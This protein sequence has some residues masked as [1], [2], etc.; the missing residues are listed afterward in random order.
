M[1]DT[2]FGL[3]THA[4]IVHAVVI[5]LPLAAAG[6]VAVALVPP[7]RRRYGLVVA[8]LAVVAVGSV[9]IATHSGAH[10][11]DRK[12]AVFGPNDT[13]EAGLMEEHRH[14]ALQLWPWALTL[15]LATLVVVGV[16]LLF[17][18][19]T[20]IGSH[21]N[22]GLGA[23]PTTTMPL[24]AKLVSWLGIAG[25]LVGAVA[26]TIMVVRIGHAG[27]KAVWDKLINNSATAPR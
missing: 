12:S 8:A 13:A 20:S 2:I 7:L 17:A 26:S 14:L 6:A 4:L 21:R 5:L 3:P 25:V 24:W 11:F 15:G 27:S 23:R 1:L 10:L 22:T 19:S 9:P 16:P 18:R